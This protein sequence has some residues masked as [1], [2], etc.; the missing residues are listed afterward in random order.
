MELRD[1]P[2]SNRVAD[3]IKP[4]LLATCAAA[5]ILGTAFPAWAALG[6]TSSRSSP[7]KFI[8]RGADDDRSSVLYRTRD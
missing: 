6:E 5:V 1:R 2:R 3:S 7:T 4:G 8:C